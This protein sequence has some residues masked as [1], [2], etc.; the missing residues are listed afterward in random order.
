MRETVL[1]VDDIAENIDVLRSTLASHYRVLIAKS[2][3]KA[4]ELATQTPSPDLILLD[5]MMPGLNG[6][7]VCRTLKSAVATRDIPVIFVTA[8]SEIEDE[9]LGLSLGAAD[10]IVKPVTPALVLARVR[11]HLELARRRRDLSD[12]VRDRTQQ[13]ERSERRY[14]ALFN[15][16]SEMIHIIDNEMRIIDANP[17]QRNAIGHTRHSLLGMPAEQ[18]IHPNS[19]TRYLE[20][21]SALLQSKKPILRERILLLGQG[22]KTLCTEMSGAVNI[23]AGK[24]T[25]A[26]FILRDITHQEEIECALRL[27]KEKA[28]H[29]SQ[30]K[31]DFLAIMSHEMRTPLNAVM[32]MAELLSDTDMDSQQKEFLEILTRSARSLLCLI[33]DLLDLSAIEA[34]RITLHS[35]DFSL[36]K[37]GEEMVRMHAI[38][39]HNKNLE[40]RLLIAPDLP[41]TLCADQLRTRQVLHNLLSNA[42]KFTDAG[43]VTL[44]I[45]RNGSDK[46]CF[47]VADTGIGVSQDM[48]T[49]IFEIFNQADTSMTRAYGGAGIGLSLCSRLAHA[50]RG[51]LCVQSA[52]GEGARFFFVLPLN[53]Q[54]NFDRCDLRL[55]PSN[56]PHN[57]NGEMCQVDVVDPTTP[58]AQAS[59]A[60]ISSD[61]AEHHVLLVEDAEDNR[62]LMQKFLQG[63]P[64]KLSI[65]EN[66]AEAVTLFQ[67]QSFDVVLMDI[68]M[69]VM[70]G[71]DA[72]RHMRAWEQEK[73][74][75]PTPILA[76]SAHAMGGDEEKSL[77]AGCDAHLTKPIRK[78]VLLETLQNYCKG[79]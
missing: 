75:A 55:T 23:E 27:A 36:A 18:I 16:A 31:S 12:Q 22:G 39:A 25:G 13:L 52:P 79:D 38:N 40:L 19:R 30:V 11:T 10:Y 50:M 63:A 29:A 54:S 21:I 9:T 4:L 48:Q 62:L 78:R 20:L 68:Q 6:Y 14:T 70:D 41:Q 72:T 73:H 51:S 67:E 34:G 3:E 57:V 7:D 76:L 43:S 58:P 45:Q 59:H 65:A 69:P 71:L 17:A 44:E 53:P 46:V 56:M 60:A 15:E 32:G 33:S 1:I 8:K 28:E 35:S 77:Q 66:G 37:V 2:G 74:K 49:Q 64:Y 61:T 26:Q 5:I 42:I 24:V 47:T